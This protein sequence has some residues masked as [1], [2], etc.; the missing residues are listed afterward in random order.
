MKVWMMVVA[1]PKIIHCSSYYDILL[2]YV[3]VTV[4]VC[5]SKICVCVCLLK[6]SVCILSLCT[7]G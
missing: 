4:L 6:S 7:Q 5:L 2:L 3:T 1:R